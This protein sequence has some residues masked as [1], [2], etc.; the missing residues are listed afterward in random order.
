LDGVF[1]IGNVTD[2]DRQYFDQPEGIDSGEIEA[3]VAIF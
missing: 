1:F 2:D 3:L